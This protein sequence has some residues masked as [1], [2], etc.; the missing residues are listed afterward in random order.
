MMK[1][2]FG[3]GAVI[4]IVAL[5]LIIGGY[6]YYSKQTPVETDPALDGLE[7]NTEE[8]IEQVDMP[9]LEEVA[10]IDETSATTTE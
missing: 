9:E 7:A 10:P 1:R 3:V 8:M 5:V 6:M 2:G 4:V